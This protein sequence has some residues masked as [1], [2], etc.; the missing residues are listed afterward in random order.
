MPDFY[1]EEQV[2]QILQKALA[3]RASKG[4]MLTR[5]QVREIAAELGV[6]AEEFALAERDYL[7]GQAVD[8]ERQ[9]FDRY[10]QRRWR[11]GVLKYAI[12]NAFLVGINFL[13]AGRIDWAIYP[14]LGWGLGIALD[15]WVT[16]QRDSEEYRK[17]FE[18][19]QNSKRRAELTGKIVSQ[20]ANKVE[21]WLEGKREG[22]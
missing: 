22:S 2:Q 7:E 10:K 15:T 14:I 5:E 6:S 20:V 16:F 11:D 18:K 12:V 9:E 13:S 17:Q 19:W 21:T 3:R 8:R 4:D 1:S